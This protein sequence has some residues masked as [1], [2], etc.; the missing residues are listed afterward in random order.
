RGSRE[1]P[2]G[3]PARLHHRSHRGHAAGGQEGRAPGEQD[4][5]GP[6]LRSADFPRAGADPHA[7][8]LR[9]VVRRTHSA[10]HDPPDRDR[11]VDPQGRAGGREAA[12]R[13]VEEGESAMIALLADHLWQSTLFLLGAG[14][15]TMLLR[16]RSP[17]VRYGLWFAASVKFLIPLA[18]LFAAG[19][20]L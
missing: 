10:A 19:E 13:T 17:G 1:L 14:L 7:R 6:P 20:A 12:P 4:R 2:R 15:L 11:S 3:Q 5:Q 16:H 9:A 18:L 8:R